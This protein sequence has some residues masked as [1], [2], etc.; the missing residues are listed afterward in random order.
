MTDRLPLTSYNFAERQAE[1]LL[2]QQQQ[3]LLQQQDPANARVTTAT[4]PKSTKP[5][6]PKTPVTEAKPAPNAATKDDQ[7]QV[8]SSNADNC[9][10][11][12]LST[13]PIVTVL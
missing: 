13:T 7:P 3:Q 2:Q 4:K 12:T 9:S 5:R 1:Q 10:T 8:S 6:Q 11:P